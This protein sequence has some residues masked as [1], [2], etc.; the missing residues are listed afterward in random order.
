[1]DKSQKPFRT[2]GAEKST[3]RSLML[4]LVAGLVL[5]AALCFGMSAIVDQIGNASIMM[6]KLHFKAQPPTVTDVDGLNSVLGAKEVLTDVDLFHGKIRPDGQG[7]IDLRGSNLSSAGIDFL[8]HMKGI[9]HINMDEATL[10]DRD[11]AR[12]LDAGIPSIYARGVNSITDDGV[13]HVKAS[14]LWRLGLGSKQVTSNGYK[15]I[16]DTPAIVDLSLV[17]AKTFSDSDLDYL[18]SHSYNM[19]TLD[20]TETSITGTNL[21]CLQRLHHLGTLRLNGDNVPDESLSSLIPIKLKVLQLTN[22]KTTDAA[23]NSISKMTS[24]HELIVDR[25]PNLTEDGIEMLAKR[26]PYCKINHSDATILLMEK[27]GQ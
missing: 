27:A 19:K 23:L 18:A 8:L 9:R 17:G 7:A 26:L 3:K 16:A 22:T 25:C 13:S 2:P 15:I 14:K 11:F 1:M 21:A 6:K 12:I 4:W 20:L 10:S 24:L 5:T